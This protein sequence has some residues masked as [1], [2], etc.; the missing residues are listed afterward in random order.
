MALARPSSTLPDDGDH[1]IPGKSEVLSKIRSVELLALPVQFQ[2][3]GKCQFRS[4][5]NFISDLMSG[6]VE[7]GGDIAL[8]PSS[9]LLSPVDVEMSKD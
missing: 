5:G 2:S 4:S 7:S 9:K 3:L 6:P 8:L 1:S